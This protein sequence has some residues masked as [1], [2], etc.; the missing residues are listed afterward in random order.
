MRLE[1]DYPKW[2]ANLEPEDLAFVKKF[3][4]LSG[5]L[6]D[7]AKEYGVTYPTVRLR[8]DRLIQKVLLQDE[9]KNDD[10]INTIKNLAID[11]KLSLDIAKTLI[12]EYKK[13]RKDD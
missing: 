5:S 6:K 12:S 11:E 4:V 8:L 2:L 7:I 10:Y 1:D 3:V 13:T 9:Q